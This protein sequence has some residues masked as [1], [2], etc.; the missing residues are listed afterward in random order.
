MERTDVRTL[1]RGTR[2]GKGKAWQDRAGRGREGRMTP[3]HKTVNGRV[4][5]R[6]SDGEC[7]VGGR[8]GKEEGEGRGKQPSLI[9]L[10]Y[11]SAWLCTR[12][13]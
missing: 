5:K 11:L 12:H 9:P 10:P 6:E 13:N 4:E 1:I 7:W 8:G 2:G 3:A